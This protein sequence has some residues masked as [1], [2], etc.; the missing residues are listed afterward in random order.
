M[1]KKHIL[2]GK[3]RRAAKLKKQI[4]G[5]SQKPRLSVFRTNRFIYAQI[6]NDEKKVTLIGVNE[7]EIKT[8]SGN[9]LTKTQKAKMAGELLGAKAKKLKILKVV[10]DRNGYKYMG[11]VK[12]FAE[13]ARASGLQF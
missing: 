7:K 8:T 12:S 5:S 11:R 3:A 9:K 10:F 2:K 13:G 4:R 1:A 6:I